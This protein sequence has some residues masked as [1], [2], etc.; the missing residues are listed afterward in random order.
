MNQIIIKGRLTR[1]PEMRQTQSGINVTNFSVA[2]DRRFTPKGEEK[3]CDFF[4]V[5]AW[6]QTGEFVSKYFDRGQEIIIQ[7]AMQSR[8]WEDK[9]GNK[10]LSWDLI[11]DNVEFCGPK[12]D[13]T[14][15]AS[16][17]TAAPLEGPEM[18][19]I[20]DDSELPF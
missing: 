12:R 8:H 20:Q 18:T 19:E 14:V 17:G 11:A 2:V 15:G 9:Q 1:A 10:R 5:V 3:Q 6:R 13:G 7:G 4:D 16:T